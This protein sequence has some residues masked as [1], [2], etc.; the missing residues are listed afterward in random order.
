MERGILSPKITRLLALPAFP[1]RLPRLL[2][3]R[4]QFVSSRRELKIPCRKSGCF[5]RA[6]GRPAFNLT[7][8]AAFLNA[9]ASNFSAF[10]RNWNALAANLPPPAAL[11]NLLPSSYLCRFRQIAVGR[12]TPCAPF[13][14]NPAPARKELSRPTCRRATCRLCVARRPQCWR[15]KVE[16]LF[17]I[18]RPLRVLRATRFRLNHQRSAINHQLK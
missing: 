8:S 16:F 15:K 13:P 18:L 5:C 3:R 1:R 10:A 6:A 12:V 9:F 4:P 11:G 7:P 14:G 2:N 17:F